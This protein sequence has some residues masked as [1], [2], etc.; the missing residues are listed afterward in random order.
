MNKVMTL[1][2][3]EQKDRRRHHTSPRL[4]T[5]ELSWCKKEIH[6]SLFKLPLFGCHYYINRTYLLINTEPI[7]FK[8]HFSQLSDLFLQPLK[9][10]QALISHFSYLLEATDRYPTRILNLI[11]LKPKSLFFFS[12]TN[13][14]YFH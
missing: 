12:H 9:L 11:Y 10:S 8:Y 5:P 7:K 6:F 14:C 13:S 2:L 3:V 4:L 1:G